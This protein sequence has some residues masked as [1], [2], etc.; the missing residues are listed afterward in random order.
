VYNR[1]VI[2]KAD[3]AIHTTFETAV[4]EMLTL[5]AGNDWFTLSYWPENRTRVKRMLLD[6]K[7]LT[8]EG[9]IFDPGCG[10]GY[11]SFLA[12][13]LGY[14]VTACDSWDIT[15][16]DELFKECGV[17]YFRANLNNLSPWPD[18]PD[19]TFD[20]VLFGEVLEH[21]LNHPVGLLRQISR[22]S[23]RMESCC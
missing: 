2:A 11:I 16:R 22:V 23:N 19:A 14:Q 3:P 8:P 12:R 5:W 20:A 4:S 18:I 21:I 7:R 10:N 13:R 6:L 9:H 1:S 15:R 17:G